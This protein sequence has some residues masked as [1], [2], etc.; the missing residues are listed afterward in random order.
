[1]PSIDPRFRIAIFADCHLPV[2]PDHPD[3]VTF[4]QNLK[5]AANRAETVVLLGD[6]FQVWA[7]I[8]VFDHKNGQELLKTIKSLSEKCKTVMVEGNWDFYIRKTYAAY[9][10]E[11]SEDAVEI[12]LHGKRIV[13]VH[14]HMDHLFSD[15]LLM[16]ILKSRPAHTL[17]KTKLFSGLA[18]KLNRKFKEGEF[19]KPVQP[20]EL[21]TVARRLIRRFPGSDHI[22][23]GHF[24]TA[25]QHGNV[26]I[27]PDY[28]STGAFL[29][30]GDSISL[31][32]F[33]KGQ[34]IPHNITD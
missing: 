15:R 5:Q 21:L 6:I 11:I 20:E 19:S 3:F 32:R 14:G 9:F 33:H 28:R 34:I 22:F 27:I 26:T 12:N 1:M 2:E 8:P 25:F 4:L 18:R 31:C 16:R 23:S 13:F 24:H 7:A 10:D 30:V 17:F 29:C